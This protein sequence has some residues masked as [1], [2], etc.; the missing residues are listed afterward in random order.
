MRP[1][2]ENFIVFSFCK[3]VADAEKV[4][5]SK[6]TAHFEATKLDVLDCIGQ[7]EV[8][9][10]CDAGDPDLIF[11]WAIVEGDA[12][13]HYALAKRRLWA[14][15]DGA[16]MLRQLLADRW[17]RPCLVTHPLVELARAGLTQPSVWTA[18]AARVAA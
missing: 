7:G 5:P 2:D 11:A 17:D 13:V 14:S 12:T 8:R 10:C 6:L 16:E 1:E 4:P 18:E 15:G 3:S 9:V